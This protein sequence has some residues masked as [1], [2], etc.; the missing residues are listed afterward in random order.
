MKRILFFTALL[1]FAF[2]EA[3]RTFKCDYVGHVGRDRGDGDVW[4]AFRG[5]WDG[6]WVRVSWVLGS[7]RG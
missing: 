1:C 3:L 7:V 6:F 5:P 4:F 2:V